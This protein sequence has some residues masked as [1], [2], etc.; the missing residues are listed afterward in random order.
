MV[1]TKNGMTTSSQVSARGQSYKKC[2]KLKVTNNRKPV[3]VLNDAKCTVCYYVL[4]NLIF[5]SIL[6]QTTHTEENL[7]CQI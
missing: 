6:P 2:H 7:F 4:S 5:F 1:D 3:L